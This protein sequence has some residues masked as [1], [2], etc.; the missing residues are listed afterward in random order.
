MSFESESSAVSE[1]A[2]GRS[3]RLA[4]SSSSVSMSGI[5][6]RTAGAGGMLVSVGSS[7]APISKSPAGRSLIRSLAYG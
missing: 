2:C 4:A 5:A 3:V 7:L 1:S 6:S